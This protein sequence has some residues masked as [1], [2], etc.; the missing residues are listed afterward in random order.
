MPQSQEIFCYEKEKLL[1]NMPCLKIEE[2]LDHSYQHHFKLQI[3]TFLD[4]SCCE[5]VKVRTKLTGIPTKPQRKVEI[6]A[7]A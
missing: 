6:F 4:D 2:K 5:K 3:T 7:H 1:H